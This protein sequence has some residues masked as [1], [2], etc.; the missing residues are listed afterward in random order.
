[1]NNERDL[2]R[3][4]DTEFKRETVKILNELRQN[5][6]ELREDINS[7]ADYFIKELENIRRNQEKFKK[8][9]CRD[10]N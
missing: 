6:K 2:C 8:F 3:L 9:I 5:I 4:I 1:M 7:N 10:S